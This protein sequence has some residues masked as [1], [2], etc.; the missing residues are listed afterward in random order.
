MANSI[1]GQGHEDKDLDTNKKNLS[2]EK[3][4][5]N[6]KALIFLI[7][8]PIFFFHDIKCQGQK[9]SYQ[10]R[11]IHVK[12]ENSGTHC[13]NVNSNIKVFRS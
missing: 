12:Y 13:W 1:N 3:L 11:N 6:M 7:L 9:V 8:L 5:C 2:Q 10:Q 4:M